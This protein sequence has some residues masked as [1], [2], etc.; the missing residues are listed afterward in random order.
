MSIHQ[1]IRD[2]R[3]A[4]GLSS[5]QAL[6]TLV[7]VSWQTVQLWEKEGGTAP[8]RS[9]IGKVAEVLGVT[10]NWLQSGDQVAVSQADDSIKEGVDISPLPTPPRW[11]DPEA[12]RV[13]ELYYLLDERRRGDAIRY[14]ETMLSGAKA[15]AA[16]SKV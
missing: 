6:A 12:Y 7:G 9:R 10:S 4:L 5:H 3:I 11:I 1:R 15:A 2:R 8:N 14:L 13:L 16:R